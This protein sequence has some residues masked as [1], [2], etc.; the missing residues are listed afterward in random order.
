MLL[1]MGVGSN[2]SDRKDRKR[3]REL[4]RSIQGETNGNQD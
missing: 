1:V 3:K 2:N 4:R